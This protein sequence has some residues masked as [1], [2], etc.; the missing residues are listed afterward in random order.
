MSCPPKSSPPLLDLWYSDREHRPLPA[1]SP[2][3]HIPLAFTHPR[4][5]SQFHPLFE[6]KPNFF[7]RRLDVVAVA[8]TTCSAL[9]VV[10]ITIAGAL[11]VAAK[12][13]AA[14]CDGAAACIGAA[15]SGV[16]TVNSAGSGPAAFNSVASGDTIVTNES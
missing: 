11:A 12:V 6:S 13:V 1:V 15:A 10:A 14:A 3:D 2:P 7:A 9:A 4:R 8:T 16:A 5:L